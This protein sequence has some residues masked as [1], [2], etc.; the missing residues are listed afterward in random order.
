MT[1]PVAMLQPSD[2]R[3]QLQPGAHRPLGVV[4]MGLR[5]AE[6]CQHAV[7]QVLGDVAVPMSTRAPQIEVP[8]P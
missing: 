7:A 5:V 4:L 8:A 2:R 6:V 3:D 1:T